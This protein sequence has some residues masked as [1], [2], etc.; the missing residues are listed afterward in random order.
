MRVLTCG[1]GESRLRQPQHRDLEQ[2]SPSA[3]SVIAADSATSL[4]GYGATLLAGLLTGAVGGAVVSASHER[5]E[6]FRERMIEAAEGFL[7]K[8][9]AFERLVYEEVHAPVIELFFGRGRG[10]EPIT[11]LDELYGRFQ[12]N[13][14]DAFRDLLG[15]SERVRIVFASNMAASR[16]VGETT[17]A[18]VGVFNFYHRFLSGGIVTAQNVTLD[19]YAEET[20]GVFATLGTARA[21]FVSAVNEAIRGRGLTR[22]V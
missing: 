16:A 3:I 18:Y 1:R 6:R 21:Q 5:A 19:A 14:Q 7:T 9:S 12:S 11:V 2:V 17:T 15:A 22:V 13:A 20:N 4:V 10:S 8:G